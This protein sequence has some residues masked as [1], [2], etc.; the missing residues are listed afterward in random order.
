MAAHQAPPSMG[1]SRQEYWSG[2]PSP[3]PTDSMQPLSKYQRH[4]Y[5]VPNPWPREGNGNPL[6]YSCL[7]NPMDGGA[8]WAAIYGVAQSQTRLKWLSS[9]SK[10]LISFMPVAYFISMAISRILRQSC[11]LL[12]TKSAV[13]HPGCALESPG[14]LLKNNQAWNPPAML[15]G[16]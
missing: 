12:L 7:E 11:S 3:S 2:V 9:S 6:Q 5:R 8:W 16:M 4:F 1:F 13:L 10:P 14:V 15:V